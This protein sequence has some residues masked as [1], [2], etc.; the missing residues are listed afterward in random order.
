MRIFQTLLQQ[1]TSIQHASHLQL[2]NSIDKNNETV[3]FQV[4]YGILVKMYIATWVSVL[5][6]PYCNQNSNSLMNLS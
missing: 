2:I 1:N 5:W 6:E 3:I 4:Q